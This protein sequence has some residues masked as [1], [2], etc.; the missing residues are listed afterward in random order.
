MV[1][2]DF[3]S[4]LLTIVGVF[5]VFPVMVL[6]I[7]I[8]GAYLLPPRSWPS[9][10][11]PRVAVL[12]PAHNEELVIGTTLAG[13]RSQ[14]LPKDRL[15][16]VADN[17]SDRT[18]EIAAAEGA[19]VI[20]R[21][22]LTRR[23][24]GYALDFG[25]RHLQA[26]PP[27]VVIIIDADCELSPGALGQLASTSVATN[28]PVQAA[29]QM[30]LPPGSA[31]RSMRIAAFAW[32]LRNI[33]R[34]LGLQRLGLPC[35]LMGT[36][37]AFPWQL[38]SEADLKSGEIVEDLA[39]GLQLAKGGNAPLFLPDTVVSSV[40]PSSVEG[41]ASQR[42]RWETGHLNAIGRYA[43]PIF[44]DA[45]LLRSNKQAVLLA[46]DSLVPPLSFFVLLLSGHLLVAGVFGMLTGSV[47]AFSIGLFNIAAVLSSVILLGWWRNGRDVLPLRE[48]VYAVAYSL[49]K[50]PLYLRVLGGK[51]LAW[52]RTRRD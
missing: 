38:V 8:V 33:V 11:R 43:L 23:G 16:V 22:D 15:V 21:I 31:G 6:T 17:C 14:L 28:R 34:P 29:Y 2:L 52:I 51:Q 36:G 42:A 47:A 26:D 35:Q 48:L 44:K 30:F 37:M 13:I 49:G 24:K 25:L 20:D 7:E 4:L 45:L 19:E 32:I 3:M 27:A 10:S 41:Q 1:L 5:L 12:V 46:A 9:A 18:G 50:I 40:F 39:L